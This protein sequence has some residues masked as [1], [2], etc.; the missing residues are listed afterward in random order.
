MCHVEHSRSSAYCSKHHAEYMR[1]WR[2]SHPLTEEQ[3]VK[4][5]ARSYAG[6][7]LKRGKI[8]RKPCRIE[9]CPERA[10]MHHHDYSKPLQVEWYCRKHHLEAHAQK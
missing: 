3:K 9:G 8:E 2:K 10:Q 6:E 7:Y 5:R 4:D 1:Q